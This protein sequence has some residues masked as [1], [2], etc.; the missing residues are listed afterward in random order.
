MHL[1]R[2]LKD[3]PKTPSN[4]RKITKEEKTLFKGA[5]AT[6]YKCNPRM[7]HDCSVQQPAN[8]RKY[9]RLFRRAT[10]EWVEKFPKKVKNHLK[11]AGEVCYQI[12]KVFLSGKKDLKQ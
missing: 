2:T 6:V 4:R 3:L 1:Q 7:I 11:K 9:S 10:R 5:F 12:Y 8:A